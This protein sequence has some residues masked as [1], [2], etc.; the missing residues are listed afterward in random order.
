L[1]TKRQ[2]EL[3]LRELIA[4]L[5][6]AGDHVHANLARAMP[7]PRVIQVDLPDLDTSYWTELSGGRMGK[8]HRGASEDPE[9]R[10]I[11]SSDDLVEVLDGSKSLFSSYKAGHIK[12]EASLWDVMA[13]RKLM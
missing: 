10:L 7:D 9:I 5:D 3:R 1:A 2:V 11:S 6:Q 13:L 8:L 12:V 4:K